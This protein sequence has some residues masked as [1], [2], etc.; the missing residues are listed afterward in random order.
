MSQLVT[1]T[2]P[3]TL[4][5]TAGAAS[6]GVLVGDITPL[7]LTK[8]L[9]KSLAQPVL[10][11]TEDGSVYVDETTAAN[12]AT[13]DDVEIV[14][15]TI[16][17]DDAIYVGHATLPF[18]QID[19]N[20]TTQGDYTTT[21]FAVEYFNGAAWAAVSGLTD[22]TSA[23][24]AAAGLVSTTFTAPVDQATCLVDNTLGY[25]IRYRCTA[26]GGSTT[27]C[28]V[29]QIWAVVAAANGTWTDDT[30]D[31]NDA[32]ASDVA[33]VPA[34]PV[35]GDGFYWVASEKF[36]KIKVTLGTAGVS[37]LTNTFKYWNGTAYAALTV[38]NDDS[39]NWTA[40]TSTYYIHF[41][42]P[43]DW[44]ANTAGN[45]PNGE[46]GWTIASEITAFTSITTVALATQAW[47]LPLVTGATGRTA[48][49][50]GTVTAVDM[51]AYTV[52]GT[53]A[54]SIFLLVNDTT[55]NFVAF[56]W[57][58]AEAVDAVASLSLAVAA[59]AGLMLIQIQGDGSTELANAEFT[60]LM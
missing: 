16:A 30:T 3:I 38:A 44:V 59:T 47:V 33:L 27:P 23:F 17:E 50:S 13:A 40:G 55:G 43:S 45:G 21:T 25:W 1:M 48:R 51:N 10:C 53:T 12:E 15:T 54:D 42:P 8:G 9:L 34:H 18:N 49:V 19:W 29:G 46:A 20:I 32:G 31:I 28:Q 5:T 58:K 14:G 11:F 37:T 2:A 41:Q 7:A 4:G 56:T 36:C 52:S 26:T 24:E 22:G 6:D 39:A 60:Y 35:V 57:T